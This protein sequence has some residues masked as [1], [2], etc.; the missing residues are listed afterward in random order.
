MLKPITINYGGGKEQHHYEFM[1]IIFL[2]IFGAVNGNTE[3]DVINKT[4]NYCHV[5][6]LFCL[7]YSFTML[8]CYN[9]Y[10]HSISF[11]HINDEKSFINTLMAKKEIV[12]SRWH[13]RK[14]H[15]TRK[16]SLRSQVKAAQG[17]FPFLNH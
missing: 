6:T 3:N 2:N 16:C 8:L 10:Y 15:Q 13:S 7:Y 1:V 4:C 11:K 5:K 14:D 9:T 17:C 12:N